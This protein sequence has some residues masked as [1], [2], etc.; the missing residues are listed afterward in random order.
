MD[1]I[2]ELEKEIKSIEKIVKNTDPAD[3]LT[4]ELNK[5]KLERLRSE[6]KKIKRG[7]RKATTVDNLPKGKY[8]P[9]RYPRMSK[10]RYII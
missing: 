1:R 4:M 2:T 3:L 8:N 10:D 6:L 7:E 5:S 9:K